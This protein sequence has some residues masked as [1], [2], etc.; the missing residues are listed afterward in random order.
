MFVIIDLYVIH[1]RY[2]TVAVIPAKAGIQTINEC[3]TKWGNTSNMALPA[4]RRL[5]D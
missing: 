1:D 5:F 3:P 2:H 4:T